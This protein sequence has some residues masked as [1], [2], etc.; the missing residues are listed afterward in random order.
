VIDR[1]HLK[2]IVV[3][4]IASICA[5]SWLA[6]GVG[7][8]VRPSVHAWTGIVTAAAVS[9]EMLFWAVAGALGLTVIQARHRLWDWVVKPLRRRH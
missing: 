4:T 2:W 9:T 8:I 6:V 5:A 7:L 3:S 1:Q